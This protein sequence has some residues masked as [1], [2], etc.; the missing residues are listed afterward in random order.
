MPTSV[1]IYLKNNYRANSEN[2]SMINERSGINKRTNI[3]VRAAAIHV[4]GDLI[5]SIGVFIAAVVIKFN[6]SIDLSH[7]DLC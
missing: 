1:F 6:V 4:L 2:H 3:N 7:H 5:Q